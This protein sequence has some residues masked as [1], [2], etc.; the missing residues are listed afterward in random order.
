MIQLLLCHMNYLPGNVQ[1]I[2]IKLIE[3]ASSYARENG[4]KGEARNVLQTMK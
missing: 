4:W 3:E 2:L 1:R